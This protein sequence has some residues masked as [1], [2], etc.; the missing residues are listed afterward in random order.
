MS[1]KEKNCKNCEYHDKCAG[2]IFGALG[3]FLS[4]KS[5]LFKELRYNLFKV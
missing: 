4:A 1:N 5:Q 2:I 3:F